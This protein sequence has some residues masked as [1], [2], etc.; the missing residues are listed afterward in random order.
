M[1]VSEP[2]HVRWMLTCDAW[3]NARWPRGSDFTAF[4]GELIVGRVYQAEHGPDK[5]LWLWTM[6]VERPGP[7]FPGPTSGVEKQHG[8]AGRRVV[9]A[10]HALLK[11]AHEAS[12]EREE[13]L[14]S[15][16]EEEALS[17]PL[18]MQAHPS[19]P[20]QIDPAG[21]EPHPRLEDVIPLDTDEKPKLSRQQRRYLERQARKQQRQ[22]EQQRGAKRSAS[23]PKGAGE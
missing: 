3:P 15:Q 1:S 23:T 5:G 16:D 14:P 12:P 22:M 20:A 19:D 8:E 9:D 21:H 4:D 13:T 10:Y 7:P 2:A 18:G 17:S 6:S 11:H